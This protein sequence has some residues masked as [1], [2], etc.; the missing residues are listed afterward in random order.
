MI[1]TDQKSIGSL[2]AKVVHASI[3]SKFVMKIF[4]FR[5]HILLK[6]ELPH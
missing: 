4:I 6:I 3:N 1:E 5:R 2:Y